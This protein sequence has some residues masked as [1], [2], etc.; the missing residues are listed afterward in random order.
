MRHETLRQ[1]SGICLF[2][3]YF[4]RNVSVVCKYLHDS[5]GHQTRG[6]QFE[7]GQLLSVD[8]LYLNLNK[9]VDTIFILNQLLFP[10]SEK[11]LFV[12]EK[13]DAALITT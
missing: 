1:R 2:F 13:Y 3:D 4:L 5:N 9:S 10:I 6:R 7:S 12:I 8:T 11:Y